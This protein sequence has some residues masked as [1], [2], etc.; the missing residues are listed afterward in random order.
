[1]LYIIQFME[2]VF[3]N[4]LVFFNCVAYFKALMEIEKITL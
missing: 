2:G 3:L 4:I 1:M